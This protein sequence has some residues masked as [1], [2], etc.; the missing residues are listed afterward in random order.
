MGA[1]SATVASHG[2]IRIVLGDDGTESRH[3]LHALLAAQPDIDV[4][5]VVDDGDVALRLLRLLKP[6]IA[7]LDEDMAAFGGAASR[8]SSRRSSRS[9][10]SSC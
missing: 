3:A 7:L 9:S 6:D 8:A 10:A 1:G 2:R 5:G 4:V